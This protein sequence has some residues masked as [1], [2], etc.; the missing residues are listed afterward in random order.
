MINN[1]TN[2]VEQSPFAPLRIG[3]IE[4]GFPVVQAALSGYSDMSMRV[5]A[6]RFGASYAICEVMLD[7]FLVAF[8]DRSKNRHFL[9]IADEEHPVGGQLMGA[10]PIQFAA[11]AVKLVE[12][13]YDVIDINFGCPVKKVLGRCRGGFHLSQPEVAL[14]IVARTRDATP[15]EIPVTVKMRR[16][17]DDTAESRDNFFRILDGA[18]D[19]GV[20]AITVHG[21]TV[22]QRYIGPSRWEFLRDVKEHVGDKTILGSG[23]LFTAQD[24]FDMMRQTGID[25]VTVARGAIGNPWIFQQARA[26]YAGQPLPPPPTVFEQREVIQEHMRIADELYGEKRGLGHMRKFGIKYSFL[27]PDLEL[28][29]SKFTKMRTLEDWYAIRDEHY[30]EDRPGNYLNPQ[31]HAGTAEC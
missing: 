8:K 29:R 31:V 26:L 24:C 15:P 7:Q 23:D 4:L 25:G 28:V 16:G 11:G 2:L 18:F 17:I 3:E 27:H 13:G 14:E 30:C 12:A 1:Q 21:R 10:E 6:R 9:A 22:Q 20:A 5:M 19:L